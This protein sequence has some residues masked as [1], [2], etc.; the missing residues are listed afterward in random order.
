MQTLTGEQGSLHLASQLTSDNAAWPK[1]I[2]PILSLRVHGTEYRSLARLSIILP[3]N[4]QS[5]IAGQFDNFRDDYRAE[6][7]RPVQ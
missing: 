6:D 7:S 3:G 2:A 1:A 5:D 4:E